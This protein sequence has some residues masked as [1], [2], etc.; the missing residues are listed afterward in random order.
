MLVRQ[1]LRRT[2]SPKAQRQSTR[3]GRRGMQRMKGLHRRALTVK[4]NENFFQREQASKSW[5]CKG[6]CASFCTA[7]HEHLSQCPFPPRQ[8]EDSTVKTSARK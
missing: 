6:I 8:T 2:R 3:Q 5:Q 7:G 4:W 1:V